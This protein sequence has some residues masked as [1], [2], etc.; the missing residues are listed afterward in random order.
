MPW[1][2]QTLEQLR[3]LNRDNITAKLRSGP[4]I[5]NSVL[6]VMSDANA[7]L[8]Y[9]TLQY[10]AWLSLQLLP[11]TA[12]T[13]WL[14]RHANIWIGGRKAAT[15]AI[16]TAT[17]T[18]I[19]GTA[20]PAGAQASITTA[21]GPFVFE[22]IQAVVIGAGPTTV[23]LQALSAGATQLEVGTTLA[24]TAGISGA[25][26]SITLTSIT[27]GIDQE[28]DDELRTR[29]LDRIREPPMGGDAFDYVQWA[30]QYPGVTRAW[31]SPNEMGIGT[32][33]V[34]FMMDDLRATTN[35]S[36]NGFPLSSDVTAV[37][38]FLQTKRPVAIKDFFVAAPI[39]QPINFTVSGLNNNN[40]TVQA[41]IAA[42][43]TKMLAQQ[44]MP[45]SAING[46]GQP[47]TTI[48]A[49]WVSAAIMAAAGVISF[50]LTMG[51]QLP[52]SNGSL[53]VL[54]TITY[55]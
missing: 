54:G 17:A 35:P 10:L 48:F 49:A 19:T 7:A 13:A 9:L 24:L 44:A 1:Q 45:A 38:N 5:P 53:A 41:A 16:G 21:N 6:R 39:P 46:V 43:V 25:D 18:G 29:V 50:D 47:A 22:I 3:S 15:F 20:I 12:E 23:N 37:Y 42:S 4:M 33:T 31:C 34:R 36:T 11:D 26:A 32:V 52:A 55:D 14:D 8:A 27:D 51:D 40:A 30:L 2:S 28:T